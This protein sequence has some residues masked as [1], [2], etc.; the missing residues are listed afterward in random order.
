MKDLYTDYLLSSFG[1]TTATATGL[2]SALDDVSH[3]QITRFLSS[4]ESG[5][6]GLW[7]SVKP[8]VRAHEN[9][10]TCLIFDDSIIE[11]EHTDENEIVCW[12]MIIVK[13]G[14]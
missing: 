2:S 1:K 10:H 5:S 12:Q 4:L 14:P 11:K 13:T 9:E 6:K 3:D 7:K 8:L